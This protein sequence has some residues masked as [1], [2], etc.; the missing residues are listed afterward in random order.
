MEE[1]PFTRTYLESLATGDLIKMAD[2][3]GLDIPDNP[4]RVLVIEEL[5]ETSSR[6]GDA[7]SNE[8]EITDP[9][10]T[11]A[12]PLSKQYNISV[13]EVMIRDPLWAFVFW[14]VK[15]SDEEQ[16]GKAQ[17]FNG[18]YLKISPLESHKSGGQMSCGQ[19]SEGVFTIPVKSEDTARYLGLTNTAGDG[20]SWVEQCQYK[21]EFC[22]DI[23]GLETVLAVSNPVKLPGQPVLPWDNQR[24]RLL[25][26]GDFHILRRSERL[27]RTKGPA[28]SNE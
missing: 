16:Y 17:D 6:D 2:D 12:A 24:A 13:I 7:A 15:A 10:I 23:G 19:T 9:V 11:E 25:G 3:L 1:I 4:D 5:L 8:Q 21:V 14:E 27:L 22:A 28:C 26:Y 18:Y 20:I